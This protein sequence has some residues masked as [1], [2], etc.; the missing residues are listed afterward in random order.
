[1]RPSSAAK[2]LVAALAVYVVCD[3]LLTPLAGLETRP[4]AK[5]T[6]TGFVGLALLFIGLALAIISIVL[7]F[8][9]SQ[10]SPVVRSS[11]PF[12]FTRRFSPSRPATSQLFGRPPQSNRL[13]LSRRWLP[14]LL[15]ASPFGYDRATP[16]DKALLS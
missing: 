7:V 9:R 5:V 10:R 4:V 6:T 2:L 12:C 13:R 16:A 15:S 14:S 1:M 3:I 11:P 8:G